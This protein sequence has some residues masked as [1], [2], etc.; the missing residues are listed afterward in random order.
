M[1]WREWIETKSEV[2]S[3][4]PVFKGTRIPVEQILDQLGAG[5]SQED[6]LKNYPRLRHEHFLAA[7]A[8]AAA[9]LSEEDVLEQ[10]VETAA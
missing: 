9:W 5:A 10:T 3:G 8:F 7:F 1:N 4:K 2:L 6:L